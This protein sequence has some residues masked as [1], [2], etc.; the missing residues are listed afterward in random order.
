MKIVAHRGTWTQKHEQNTIAA[1]QASV[2][3]GYGIEFDV[4]DY[5]GDLVI[6]H[7]PPAN[8]GNT[9]KDLLDRIAE[10]A[11]EK[12]VPLAINVKSDGLA[13][14]ITSLLNGYPRLDGFV[15]DMAVPD[16]R[17]Y[18]KIGMPTFARL[19]DAEPYISYGDK[20][21]GVWLDALESEDM[22]KAQ[23]QATMLLEKEICIVS[24]EL[25]RRPHEA[26]WAWLLPYASEP[27][28]MIC[29]D[30]PDMANRYFN[31]VQS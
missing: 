20:V 7:D 14:E 31:G 4:R 24:S 22:I 5:A 1:L 21:Q 10:K 8:R 3:S 28:L 2:E 26:L 25:H 13:S 16:M 19:S 6:S 17:Q 29:T 9:F 18:L 30:F 23:F 12:K 11:H 27:N 15:F